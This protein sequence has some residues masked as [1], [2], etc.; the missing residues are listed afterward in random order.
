MLERV[1]IG[2]FDGITFTGDY[3]SISFGSKM[4]NLKTLEKQS[5][6]DTSTF[7]QF[8]F[9]DTPLDC[10]GL[11]WLLSTT[12]FKNLEGPILCSSPAKIKGVDLLMKIDAWDPGPIKSDGALIC[13]CNDPKQLGQGLDDDGKPRC[14]DECTAGY[15][16]RGN[17]GDENDA[18][19]QCRFN[20]DGANPLAVDKYCTAC[21]AGDTIGFPDACS[22]C[23]DN[24]YLKAGQGCVTDCGV[25]AKGDAHLGFRNVGEDKAGRTC[26]ACDD[27]DNCNKCADNAEICTECTNDYHLHEGKCVEQCPSQL[28]LK[29]CSDAETLRDASGKDVDYLWRFVPTGGDRDSTNNILTG[30]VC[31]ETVVE[32]T[33]KPSTS[34]QLSPEVTH[35]R[36]STLLLSITFNDTGSATMSG[37]DFDD[38]IFTPTGQAQP[39][40]DVGRVLAKDA[41]LQV[42]FQKQGKVTIDLPADVAL[43][44]SCNKNTAAKSVSV[45]YDIDPPTVSITSFATNDRVDTVEITITDTL[46]PIEMDATKLKDFLKLT[47][48]GSKDAVPTLRFGSSPCTSGA[49]DATTVCTF[50]AAHSTAYS[51]LM[52]YTIT[53]Q[54]SAAKDAAGNPTPSIESPAYHFKQLLNCDDGYALI[55]GRCV[56]FKLQFDSNTRT[57]KPGTVY[58]DPVAMSST[59]YAVNES[60]RVAPFKILPST[61]PSTGNLSDITYTLGAGAPDNFFLSTTSGE[62]FWRFEEANANKNYTITLNAVDKGGAKQPIETMEMKVMFDDKSVADYG[63]NKRFCNASN[64]KQV[65]D[66]VKFNQSFSCECVSGFGGSNCD[67]VIAICRKGEVKVDGECFECHKHSQPNNEQTEC[68]IKE[69]DDFKAS[70]MPCSCDLADLTDETL[71]TINVTCDLASDGEAVVLFSE[72]TLPL[73]VTQLTL[74]SVDSARLPLLLQEISA[75]KSAST[76]NVPASSSASSSSTIGSIIVEQDAFVVVQPNSTGEESPLGSTSPDADAVIRTEGT[77]RSIAA[78][79]E[80]G[81]DGVVPATDFDV[82][83]GLC[84]E[85]D[86]ACGLCPLGEFADLG[87]GGTCTKC[88]K[89]GFYA[90]TPGRVGLGSHCG[91]SLCKPGT[92]ASE[93]G[94]SDPN[95]Q[96][97][98][99]P[100]NTQTDAPAGYRACACLPDF[101][102]TDR[103][104]PCSSCE[105]A[106]G[107]ECKADARVLKQDYFW[108]F[109]DKQKEHEYLEFT[110]DLQRSDN[111]NKSLSHFN[112]TY[113]RAYACPKTGTCLGVTADAASS[114]VPGNTGPLCAVCEDT[115]FRLNGACNQCPKSKGGSAVLLIV[116][117]LIFILAVWWIL[118]RNT[119]DVPDVDDWDNTETAAETIQHEKAYEVQ[120]MTM[121]KIVLGYTQIKALLIEVYPGVQWPSSY[122]S[123]TGGLQFMSSNPLSIVMPSCLATSLT[124][125]AYSEFVIAAGTP[126]LLAPIVW[127]YY[128]I[129][130]RKN[131]DKEYAGKLKAI[132]I[133]TACFAYYCLYPTIA[134]ASVRLLAKCHRICQTDDGGDSDQCTDYVEYLRADYSIECGLPRHTSYKL[135]AGVAFALYSIAVPALIAFLLRRGRQGESRNNASALMAGFSFYSKQY[136]PEYYYWET[137]DLYRKLFLTSMVVFIAEGTSMQI[138]FGIIFAVAGLSLQMMYRPYIHTDENRLAAASQVITVLALIVGGLIRATQAE[139]GAKMDSG[140]I[141]GVVLG[142][143]LVTSGAMLYCWALVIVILYRYFK[144]ESKSDGAASAASSKDGKEL[145]AVVFANAEPAVQQPSEVLYADLDFGSSKKGATQNAKKESSKPATPTASSSSDVLYADMDLQPVAMLETNLDNSSSSSTAAIA[146][147]S[148]DGAGY[149]DV[150]ERES[151]QE[152]DAPDEQFDG[153]AD[154]APAVAAAV[155]PPDTAPTSAAAHAPTEEPAAAKPASFPDGVAVGKRCS[156]AGVTCKGVIRFLGPLVDSDKLRVGVEL[157]EPLGKHNGSPK[158]SDHAYFVCAKKHGMLVPINKVELESDAVGGDETFGGF[159]D[160]AVAPAPANGAPVGNKGSTLSGIVL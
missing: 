79:A 45:V 146:E 50:E 149:L 105:G 65:V 96:C 33:T 40:A 141:D 147:A 112:G 127:I 12:K 21:K 66:D 137:V 99:C 44:E 158:G 76:A 106:V 48:L 35:T 54:S 126:L 102:R 64:T 84:K 72:L 140:N 133:S 98:V 123:F 138:S 100:L 113:P 120:F 67:D 97:Q 134:V 86:A 143:Y 129:K 73:E 74:S 145:E 81:M 75:S 57:S 109:P 43:D 34:L 156:V 121:V 139:D 80:C 28:K 103:F 38:V 47:A 49:S 8:G 82:P 19:D 68:T 3:A 122:R 13:S 104:G 95:E 59:F 11:E 89:G 151:N 30:S 115:H 55:N 93:P 92:F 56:E 6:K 107:I 136:K 15:A 52:P 18:C 155:V 101:S 20:D 157:D 37:M 83:I 117:A 144:D 5:F 159:E 110:A 22:K 111:Y 53:L 26:E 24:Y 125:S 9:D 124:I 58:T 94:A 78:L 32:D 62:L 31:K 142:A 36:D 132:C 14:V 10:C 16:R 2:A 71:G 128:M 85:S 152:N 148:A 131:A 4:D 17:D 23:T 108:Q 41:Y 160:A 150:G 27:T 39:V 42:K 154:Q 63:P 153:F 51:D 29:Q 46:S 90:N 114:C 91:C 77:N 60:Y 69:C 1:A 25:D 87:N 88:D 135:A 61:T 130:T 70:N 119:Q 118:R 116:I 7:Y